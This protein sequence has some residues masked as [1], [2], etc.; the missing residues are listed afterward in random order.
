MLP[1][2]HVETPAVARYQQAMIRHDETGIQPEPP[3]HKTAAPKPGK[4]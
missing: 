1:D 3:C 4:A 2:C